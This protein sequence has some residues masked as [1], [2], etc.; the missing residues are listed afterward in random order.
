MRKGNRAVRLTTCPRH[1]HNTGMNI[2]TLYEHLRNAVE[3][4]IIA[5][6]ADRANL[7]SLRAVWAERLRQLDEGQAVYRF[8]TAKQVHPSLEDAPVV[9]DTGDREIPGEVVFASDYEVHVVTADIGEN[10]GACQLL[11]DLTFILERLY[12]LLEAQIQSPRQYEMATVEAV[13]GLR[14]A[15]EAGEDGSA[16]ALLRCM[17]EE[18]ASAER[19]NAEQRVAINRSVQFPVL[20]VWGPPGT[21]KTTTLAWI[22]E[23]CLRRGESVLL[24][25]NTNVAV[26]RALTKLLDAVGTDSEWVR[27][28]AQGAVLRLGVS[29]LPE[30]QPLLL[31]NHITAGTGLEP[32]REKEGE[33]PSMRQRM[34]LVEQA[35]LIACTLAKA[36]TDPFVRERRFDVLLVDEGSMAPLPY[37]A[38]LS[39]LCKRRVVVG[40]DFRQLPPISLVEDEEQSRWLNTD[41]FQQ[42]GIVTKDGEVRE[43]PNLVALAEQWRMR[44]PICELVNEPMYG[45]MLRTPERLQGDAEE[46]LFL[47]DTASLRACSDRTSGYSHFNIASALVCVGL[48]QQLLTE[49]PFARVG[50]V[51]PYN[52]Q[53]SLIHAMLLDCDLAHE[54]RVATVHRF[55]GEERSAI[56]FDCVD[57]PPFGWVGQFLRGCSPA[58]ESTRLLNVAITRAQNQ[59]Y[60]V[61]DSGY[62]DRKLPAES[63]LRY[64]LRR[65][66]EEGSVLDGSRYVGVALSGNRSWRWAGEA[67]F[68][69]MLQ[70]D[71][72]E[73]MRG[74]GSVTVMAPLLQRDDSTGIVNLLH[75]LLRAR[76]EVNILHSEETVLQEPIKSLQKAGARLSTLRLPRGRQDYQDWCVFIDRQAVWWG[77]VVMPYRGAAFV[78]VASRATM[79]ELQFLRRPR[80][81][82]NF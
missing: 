71:L 13:F 51:T 39:A 4:E 56:I 79:N 26:D 37:V 8:E 54:V 22:A 62:L 70:Q 74:R 32:S 11:I 67:D 19:P 73:A 82:G 18:V 20:F 44:A 24:V 68:L 10:V 49:N 46:S 76:V 35:D 59:L 28:V 72:R 23:A 1:P 12:H 52:A 80:S 33:Y 64:V 41:I 29:E 17:C 7:K 40:G 60:L 66:R 6:Q 63:L 42:A 27:R 16:V 43:R 36:V 2:H 15:M 5:Q 55:Q 81:S 9:V 53:A 50:I 75:D 57:A 38:A 31:S 61:G 58:E 47:V 21:G 3:A 14:E 78:R 25:S 77:S 34:R 48:A 30:L 65:I 45:G 69:Q